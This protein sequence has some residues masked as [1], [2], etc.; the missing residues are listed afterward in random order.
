M[1]KHREEDVLHTCNIIR[2]EE[3][4]QQYV[5]ISAVIKHFEQHV[6]MRHALVQL[7]SAKSRQVVVLSIKCVEK[8]PAVPSPPHQ[9][10]PLIVLEHAPGVQHSRAAAPVA[11]TCLDETCLERRL[12]Y[13]LAPLINLAHARLER[14]VCAVSTARRGALDHLLQT[15]VVI[16]VIHIPFRCDFDSLSL[17][18]L[19]IVAAFSRNQLPHQPLLVVQQVAFVAASQ[20][21]PPEPF[22]RLVR[23]R[24]AAR[25]LPVLRYDRRW[26]SS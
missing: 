3:V 14:R 5:Q 23:A 9:R 12:Q 6:R 1:R 7:Q 19:L 25:S 20:Q 2:L 18:L 22:F 24:V 11:S 17:S 4:H 15:L 13:V 16:L 26:R 10:V 8:P 21:P